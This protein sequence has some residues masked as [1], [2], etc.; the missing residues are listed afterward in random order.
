MNVAKIGNET[1]L[2]LKLAGEKAE[3]RKKELVASQSEQAGMSP[4]TTDFRRGYKQGIDFV[5]ETLNS[6]VKDLEI[7][8]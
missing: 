5:F 4:S 6:I 3:A 1:K 8:R 2:I 7:G